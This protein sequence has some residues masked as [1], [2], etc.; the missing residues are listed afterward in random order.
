MLSETLFA[1]LVPCNGSDQSLIQNICSVSLE[2]KCQAQKN[3]RQQKFFRGL[4]EAK[5]RLG[6]GQTF[7][8][9]HF[10]K[11]GHFDS[12][13]T[14]IFSVALNASATL[15]SKIGPLSSIQNQITHI[16]RMYMMN[17]CYIFKQASIAQW[18]S[19]RLQC[20][21]FKSRHSKLKFFQKYQISF[22]KC[23]QS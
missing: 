11:P 21:R 5:P 8:T 2:S 6:Q 7:A 15:R 22:Y 17:W 16:R 4:A 9:E 13:D 1:I 18:Q 20:E 3:A 12:R 23:R 10:S 14:D 19:I